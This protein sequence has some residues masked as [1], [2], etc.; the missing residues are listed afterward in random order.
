M[1]D[2]VLVLGGL[3]V[4]DGDGIAPIAGILVS[5]HIPDDLHFGERFA[6]VVLQIRPP[7]ADVL[8][9][10][11]DGIHPLLPCDIHSPFV[12]PVLGD[13]RER[14]LSEHLVCPNHGV[15][16]AEARVVEGDDRI[17]NAQGYQRLPHL[18][19]FVVSVPVVV[20]ADENGRIY[21]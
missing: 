3:T 16:G 20:A 17:G 2:A 13:D 11:S 4:R 15:I 14:T 19:G 5:G 18:F 1:P 12:V 8:R 9:I 21:S 10:E 6:G 7:V